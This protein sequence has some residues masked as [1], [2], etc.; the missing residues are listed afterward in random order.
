MHTQFLLQDPHQ[1]ARLFGEASCIWLGALWT[2]GTTGAFRIPSQDSQYSTAVLPIL[3]YCIDQVLA[4]GPTA[5]ASR[6]GIQNFAD[7]FSWRS[8]PAKAH[9]PHFRTGN[10]QDAD[11]VLYA[12]LKESLV[13]RRIGSGPHIAGILIE[14]AFDDRD[15]SST[16][17][18][19]GRVTQRMGDF[20]A[21]GY[22]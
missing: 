5:L 16:P 14:D 9:E 11:L 21:K 15:Q 20:S 7:G 8:L 4:D 2:N 10:L 1:N 18:V 19:A 13:E 22:F 3:L 6:R 17:G 12:E